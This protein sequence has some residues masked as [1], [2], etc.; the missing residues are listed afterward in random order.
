[1]SSWFYRR[2]TCRLCDSTDNELAVPLRPIPI[3][4]PNVDAGKA[5]QQHAGVQE[6]TVPLGLYRCRGCGA[7]QLMDVVDPAVQYNNFRYT[8]TI[9]LGLPEHF[10]KFAGE[11]MAATG[12]P[13]GG[14]VLE[15]G[16]NDGTLLRAF[17]ERGAKVL[18]VDPAQKIAE[19]ATQSGVRTLATFFTEKLARQIRAE[20]G[21]A[22]IVIA[23]N[24]F[25]NIDDLSDFAAAVRAV[26]APE[27][28]FVFE[29][30]YG[31]D[32]VQ[33][34][35]IDTVYHEHLSYFMAGPL[36]RYFARHGMQLVDMQQI[37]TKGGSIR[38]MAKL[39]A[40]KRPRLPSVEAM[41][42]EEKRL[43]FGGGAPFERMDASVARLTREIGGL[44]AARRSAGAKVA[45]YGA[46]VGTVTLI[47]QFAI[48][49]ALDFIAD[50]SPLCD[51]IAGSNYRVPVLK[52]EQ[53]YS[54]QPQTIVLLAWRY[55][56]PILARHRKFLESGGEF[57]VP[58]PEVSLRSREAQAAGR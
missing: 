2:T 8:T 44:V 23:N 27:G 24:T 15:V 50:D 34:T 31:A 29:T 38:G 9:S 11:V 19:R 4:T 37:W 47:E 16:S 26:L 41:I 49:P 10:R 56:E 21:A 1:M 20:H 33:K 17:K 48:G 12:T 58:L 54:R 32:V 51:A 13:A 57:V 43:G 52:S 5:A 40:G 14:F 3:V 25:A 7:V 28:A 35:L 18:G 36:D 22:D 53:I 39:A 45:A 55:A 30:S 46:S 6:T 42:A